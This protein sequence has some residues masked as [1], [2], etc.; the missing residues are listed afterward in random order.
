MVELFLVSLPA[1]TR[2]PVD[3]TVPQKMIALVAAGAAAGIASG[4][5]LIIRYPSV[6]LAQNDNTMLVGYG[7]RGQILLTCLHHYLSLEV[8][9][10]GF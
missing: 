1:A 2:A 9:L 6:Y 7:I 4:I 3:G 8:V 10:F 5:I